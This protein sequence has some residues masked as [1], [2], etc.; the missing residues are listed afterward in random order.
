MFL[1]TDEEGRIYVT[2]K[3]NI[4]VLDS[5]GNALKD[6]GGDV[7]KAPA[8]IDYYEGRLY[9]TDTSLNRVAIL[10][11]DGKLMESFGERGSDPGE[12]NKPMGI[13][14]NS[15][16]IYVA[17]KGN[18][19]V[20]IFGPNG[21]YMGSIG[22][23]GTEGTGLDGPTDVALDQSGRVFVADGSASGLKLYSRTGKFLGYEEAVKAPYSMAMVEDGYYAADPGKYKV[24]RC[25]TTGKARYSFGSKGDGRA[26]FKSM[27]GMHADSEGRFYMADI[28]RD[29]VHVFVPEPLKDSPEVAGASPLTSVRWVKNF[30]VKTINISWDPRGKILYAVDK[31]NNSVL[32]IREGRSPWPIS[33]DGSKPVATTVDSAG[34][35]WVVDE[36]KDQLIKLDS[37]GKVIYKVGSRG[38]GEGK[39]RNP[40]DM[41]VSSDG[42]IYVADKNN[43][44]I[45]VFNTDGV[46]LK[47]LKSGAPV[48]KPIAVA[49]SDKGLYVLD[50]EQ[51]RLVLLSENGQVLKEIGGVGE[52]RGMFEKPVDVAATKDEVFVLDAGKK[53]VHVFD[54]EG[55]LTREFGSGAQG[56]GGFKKP[57][58]L[59]FMDGIRIMVADAEVPMVQ[60]LASVYTPPKPSDFKA[61]S[62]M[63][64]VEL[65]W[66]P[67]SESFVT[68]YRIYRSERGPGKGFELLK[69]ISRGTHRSYTDTD[70]EP[71]TRYFYRMSAVAGEG[72]ESVMSS[73][74]QGV[75][76]KY[77]T[78]PPTDAKA[79]ADERT[80]TLS[81]SSE[82]E[83]YLSHFVVYRIAE[84]KS[85]KIAETEDTTY[86]D[87]EL[88]PNRI[89]SYAVTSVSTDGVESSMVSMEATT[90]AVQ[91]PPLEM[92]VLQM[93][94]VFSNAYKIYE[95]E[96]IGKIKLTNNTGFAI[97][98]LKVAF[99]MKEFVDF[100]SETYVENLSPGESREVDLR[101]VFNNRILEVTE[102]TPVQTEV[103]VS[104]YKEQELLTF[105]ENHTI[106]VYEKHRMT[107]DEPGRIGTFIT[108][109]EAVLLEFARSVV[110]QYRQADA[111]LVLAGMVF[112]A[113]GVLGIAYLPDPNNPYQETSGKT[114]FID[115]SQY[116]RETLKRKSGD[117][118]DL[119]SL[120][121]AALESLGRASCGCRLR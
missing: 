39:L 14:V 93:H 117:C 1:T 54:H 45:E 109:K 26:Q 63:H 3:E 11:T 85:Y 57:S 112:D 111:P 102:D 114:D 34:N 6:I 105:A 96:G 51:K 35:L 76:D 89:Y 19:R 18:N 47:V 69:E 98:K 43:G 13:F 33:I 40:A 84:D 59:A 5:K 28:K 42:I 23:A 16:N 108:S 61:R 71:G 37:Q 80:A 65:S 27:G 104:Y 12:F 53:R 116:P 31:D 25:D 113:M 120:Y 9:V 79:T 56:R 86:V 103:R 21:V 110:T 94:D 67:P 115:Y 7:L 17:D 82:G 22:E 99:N 97:P 55:N 24:V 107:W 70:V 106:F 48:A 95:N 32:A 88:V 4:R 49:L 101:A 119:V 72:N 83:S 29:M 60:V 100:P 41:A 50:D 38:S 77:R 52:G 90:K 64:E 44:R 74:E 36:G 78:M 68:G 8:G 2:Q 10:S 66:T 62:E 58:S 73:V 81:W 30:E 87:K 15:G 75:P 92:Q 46:F 118:D 20:Q 121:S 91:G